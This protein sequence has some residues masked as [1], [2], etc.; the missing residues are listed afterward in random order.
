MNFTEEILI[1]PLPVQKSKFF[2]KVDLRLPLD[3]V[4]CFIGSTASG[5][6]TNLL[7]L[8]TKRKLLLNYFKVF[9]FSRNFYQDSIWENICI[10]EKYI[11]LTYSESRIQR[12]L[13]RQNEL[14]EEQLEKYGNLDKFKPV[15][16]IF[17]DMIGELRNKFLSILTSMNRHYNIHIFILSQSYKMISP[18]I[19][20]QCTNWII[21]PS[22]NEGET[23]KMSDELGGKKFLKFMEFIAQKDYQFL[24]IAKKSPV[25]IRYRK[26]YDKYLELK[27]NEVIEHKLIL[28]WSDKFLKTKS[29]KSVK[30]NPKPKKKKKK[31][32]V[33]F[34][35]YFSS[36]E[37]SSSSCYD[38]D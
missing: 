16:I 25:K 35:D 18:I 2:R 14:K 31:E 12:I 8:L 38:S 5:K 30:L 22:S 32:P 26:G 19:R 37:S 11:C 9:I 1:K 17:D 15:L 33:F 27:N 20:N 4:V 24:H 28:K 34:E 6:T 21:Y 29:S 10:E 13:D 7:N 23:K 36:S 3:P